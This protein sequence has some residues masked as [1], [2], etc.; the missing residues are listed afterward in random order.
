M[1]Y[2]HKQLAR[3]D[4]LR[5]AALTTA[6]A[7]TPFAAT[8]A[9]LGDVAAQTATDYKALVCIFLFGGNDQSNTIIPYENAAYAKYQAARPAIALPQSTLLQLNLAGYAG[10]QLGLNP[11]FASL[12]PLVDAGQCALMAN[13]GTLAYP[14]TLTQYKNRT[15]QTPLGLF[16]HSD[17]QASWQSGLPTKGSA[18]GWL[19][20]AADLTSSVYNPG[21]AV[22]MCMSLGG[23][24]LIQAGNSVVQYQV[25]NNGPVVI[26]TMDAT[27]WRYNADMAAAMNT[28][29]TQQ[30]AHML[31]QAYNTVGT[32]AVATGN[33]AKSAL[34]AAPA[35]STVF[36]AGGL[37]AQLR[38]VARLISARNALGHKRQVYFVSQGGYDFHD[39]LVE[40]QAL[41]LGELSDAMAAFHAATVE[42]GVANSVTTFTASDFGRGLQSNGRG[43]DHGWGSH[44][45]I[46]GG[47]VKG[48]RLYG[49]WP[50][51]ALGGPED[52]GQ[53][54]L[55]PT[56]SVDRYAATLATWFGVS[57]ANLPTVLPN[58][59][60]FATATTAGL[61]FL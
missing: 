23:N 25:T 39:T 24:N 16:S 47:A 35:I 58:V 43:S 5:R 15:V 53:G 40:N 56:T 6:Y 28:L 49:N 9:T 44:H 31:E 8:L 59:T 50:T 7:G 2:L 48:N 19:G 14:T 54:R 26:D 34:A 12:K 37:A 17:Q 42:M 18:T 30:R 20:R 29:I 36:P 21:S 3:R 4:F 57:A 33:I 32:R 27:H 45:F 10:P 55:I 1:T 22:S 51:V 11:A 61:G 46:M 60:R 13:V 38:M 52:L 41:R